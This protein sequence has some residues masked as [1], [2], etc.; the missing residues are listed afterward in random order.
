MSKTTN[1][2]K[3]TKPWTD[4]TTA[5]G[6]ACSLC[7]SR[8]QNILMHGSNADPDM[9]HWGNV[10][11]TLKVPLNYLCHADPIVLYCESLESLVGNNLNTKGTI[12]RF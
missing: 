12:S 1:V 9:K 5:F 11:K 10:K 7:R 3:I 6:S 4:F 2:K 8:S